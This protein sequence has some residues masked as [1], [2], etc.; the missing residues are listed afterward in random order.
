MRPRNLSSS[1]MPRVLHYLKATTPSPSGG[2]GE[3]RL[4]RGVRPWHARRGRPRHLGGP[5]L[6]P[7]RPRGAPVRGLRR[8]TR[9]QAQVSSA[10]RHSTSAGIEVSRWHGAPE[11]W[12]LGAGS[13]RAAYERG[14]RG[15][16]WHSDPAEHR[17]PVL[18]GTAGGH[19]APCVD[20]GG[21]V[22]RT[23]AGS[24]ASATRPRRTM[25]CLGPPE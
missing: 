4:R 9:L 1:R 18:V 12:L 7:F 25:P 8:T 21:D 6:D 22:P 17:R 13:R 2:R 24:G 23:F 11:P 15:T 20:I 3:G 5:R 19:Q 16:R 14:R 10:I